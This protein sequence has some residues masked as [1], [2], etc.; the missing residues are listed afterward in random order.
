MQ[1]QYENYNNEPLIQLGFTTMDVKL[2]KKPTKLLKLSP[3]SL[4]EQDWLNQLNFRL[5]EVKENCE[6]SNVLH[7][8]SKRQDIEHLK[9]FERFPQSV[10]RLGKTYRYKR[11]LNTKRMQDHP[12][13]QVRCNLKKKQ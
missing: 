4:I 12:P 1:E 7:I 8:F 10:S 6:F 3:R 13:K 5:E 2:E 11:N 9:P